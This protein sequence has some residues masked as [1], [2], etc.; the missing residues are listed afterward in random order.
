MRLRG[1]FIFRCRVKAP[2]AA[3]GAVERSETEGLRGR[4]LL[5]YKLLQNRTPVTIPP[6]KI[7][8]EVPIFAHLPL[9]K[10]GV[11][12][13]HQLDKFKFREL[14]RER[15]RLPLMRELSA[16]LTEGEIFNS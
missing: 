6:S 4:H 14:A 10:G 13:V 2:L 11:G 16:K 12:A 9:H 7:G 3:R 15:L 5:Y 1:V 8:S